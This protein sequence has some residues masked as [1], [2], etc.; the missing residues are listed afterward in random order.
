MNLVINCF[1]FLTVGRM[2]RRELNYLIKLSYLIKSKE[3]FST[4]GVVVSPSSILLKMR[5]AAN[6][7]LLR[8]NKS[9]ISN[10]LLYY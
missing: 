1:F 6:P 5:E 7:F 2:C 3:T 9:T 4:Q 10:E 8:S